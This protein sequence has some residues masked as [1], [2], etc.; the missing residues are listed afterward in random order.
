M[1]KKIISQ[2]GRTSTAALGAMQEQKH[3]S[4]LRGQGG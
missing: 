4:H 1:Y 2:Q 3:Y